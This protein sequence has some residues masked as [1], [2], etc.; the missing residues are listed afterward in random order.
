MRTV[1]LTKAKAQLSD[2][3]DAAQSETVLIT[4]H[5]APRAIVI[6]VWG[7]S[8][9]AI[10]KRARRVDLKQGARRAADGSDS[11]SEEREE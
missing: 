2:I 11:T 3:V 10:L 5:G 1:P 6:G 4:R 7:L 9:D 8:A